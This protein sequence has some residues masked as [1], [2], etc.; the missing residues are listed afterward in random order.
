MISPKETIKKLYRI[1]DLGDKR[2]NYIRLDKNE[3]TI[4]FL[5]DDLAKIFFELKNIDI[6]MYPDQTPMYDALSDFLN[7]SRD[8]ILLTPGSDVGLKYIFETYV[9]KEDSIVTLWPTY[10]MAD[11]YTKMFGANTINIKYNKNLEINLDDLPKILQ[12]E[13]VCLVYIANPNQPTGTVLTENQINEILTN[14]EKE[15]VLVIID[16]AYLPFSE[17]KSSINIID[18]YSNLIVIHTFSKAFGLASARVGYIVSQP[19]NISWLSKVKPI[20]DI[21]IFALTV[22]TYLLKNYHIVED[23]VN[24]INQSKSFIEQ[25]LNKY[26]IDCLLGHAN[27]IHLKF[28]EKYNLN[29]I[30]KK[31]KDRGFL[32][33]TSGSGLPAVLENC[34]RITVGPKDQ[35]E[36]FAQNLKALM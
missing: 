5:E 30:E 29:D 15:D 33:R 21:N 16:E 18:E 31:M 36:N 23:Y 27:F 17:Q 3:R 20:H 7:L 6:S 28:P 13:E 11:V 12:K 1:I 8:K 24:D 22:G 2:S 10:A 14:A 26:G 9:K 4:P 19:Q 35:M 34:I 32:I 25:E